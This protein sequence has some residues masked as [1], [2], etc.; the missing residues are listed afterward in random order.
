[1]GGPQVRAA[2]G[3]ILTFLA[4]VFIVFPA[5][6]LRAADDAVEAFKAYLAHPPCISKIIY[7]EAS[8]ND[9]VSRTV[10]GGMCED[11]FYIRQLMG[12]ENLNAPISLTNRNQSVLYVG[13]LGDTRWQIAGYKLTLSIQPNLSKP[14]PYAGMSDGM[15]TVLNGVV[16]LGSQHVQ[17]G[18]FVWAGNKFTAK[19]SSWA[20]QFGAES[21]QGEIVVAEGLVKRMAITGSGT[22]DYKYSGATNLP[23]GMPSEIICGGSDHCTSKIFIKEIIPSIPSD[24]MKV[25]DPKERI[26]GAITTLSVYSNSIQI[27]KPLRGQAI[28]TAKAELEPTGTVKNVILGQPSK[29]TAVERVVILSTMLLLFVGFAILV[30]RNRRT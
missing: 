1:M 9:T 29:S 19:A 20:R 23:L 4:S 25:F 27:V 17:P 10:V 7:S 21:F 2:L 22:W 11:S 12:S 18:T 24:E 13:R 8:C 15:K 30:I 5:R 6:Q 28:Q 3:W 26:D 14:D 16:N